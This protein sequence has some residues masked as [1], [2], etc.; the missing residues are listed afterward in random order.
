MRLAAVLVLLCAPLAF[1]AEP[2]NDAILDDLMKQS[3]AE[4]DPAKR[5]KIM[6]Q[7]EDIMLKGYSVTPLM[8][9]ASLWLVSRKIKGFDENTVNEHMTKYLSIE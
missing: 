4:R 8:N 7:A 3:Y 9:S 5:M 6:E 2:A 1:A